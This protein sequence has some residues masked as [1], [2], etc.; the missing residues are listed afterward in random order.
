M[1]LFPILNGVWQGF[2]ISILLFGPAFFKLIHT[3]IQEG[4]KKGVLLASGVFFSD[5]LVVGLCIFGVAD[6][7]QSAPFQKI[8]SVCGAIVLLLMG[9]KSFRHP[10]KAFLQSYSSRVPASKNVFKGFWLNLINPFTFILWFNVMGSISLKY[11][12]EPQYKNLLTV[13]L[14]TILLVLFLMDVLKVFLSH[15]IGKKLNARIFFMINK[16]FGVL[17]MLIGAFFMARF[18]GLVIK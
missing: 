6:F 16:Y 9:I 4:F 5:L 1:Y 2:L 18:I 7:M 14:V 12:D 3:S 15:L 11:A 8:Y 10:Y 17:L 13:N